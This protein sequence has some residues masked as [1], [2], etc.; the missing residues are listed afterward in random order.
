[1]IG[2]SNGTGARTERE[3]GRQRIPTRWSAEQP[4]VLRPAPRWIDE[5]GMARFC[6][7]CEPQPVSGWSSGMCRTHQR[8]ILGLVV[9]PDAPAMPD[10]PDDPEADDLGPSEQ[11][12]GRPRPRLS[13]E[14]LTLLVGAFAAAPGWIAFALAAERLIDLLG[15]R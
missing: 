2:H 14:L 1:M 4:A 8:A 15:G 5:H 12:D 11:P 13:D 7:H 3:Q 9:V 6:L 10:D